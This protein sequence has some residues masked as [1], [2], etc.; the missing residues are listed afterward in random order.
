MIAMLG[1]P[2]HT[3]VNRVDTLVPAWLKRK[4]GAVSPHLV[5][6]FYTRIT[7]ATS[8]E[9]VQVT[10]QEGEPKGRRRRPPASGL[11]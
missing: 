1:L 9:I 5:D 11:P 8:D 4:V 7:Q 10:I 6:D 2:V 3:F